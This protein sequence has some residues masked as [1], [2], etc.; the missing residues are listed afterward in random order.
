MQQENNKKL[1]F[2]HKIS[3]QEAAY[4]RKSGL[5]LHAG[6]LLNHQKLN[7]AKS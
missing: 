2:I 3:F 7:S 4:I 6:S 1:H 5:H